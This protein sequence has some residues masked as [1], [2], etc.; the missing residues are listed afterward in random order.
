MFE[1]HYTEAAT[2]VDEIAERIRTLGERAPGSYKEF[3]ELST[4]REETTQVDAQEMIRQ[5]VRDHETVT[6]VAR[7]VF[8][9]AEEVHDEPSADLLTQRMQLHEKTAWMLRSLLD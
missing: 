7:E 9:L 6:K 8:K 1:E 3:D 4:V 2:A 5:L